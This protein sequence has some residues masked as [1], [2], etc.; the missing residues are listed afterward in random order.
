MSSYSRRRIP[1]ATYFFTVNLASRGGSD[2]TDRID[3]LRSAYRKTV[4]EHPVFC[5]AMVIL[6][7]HL[8]AVWTLPAQ[9][10]GFPERWRKIKAR[11]SHAIGEE[12]RRSSSKLAK[13]E[14]GVWQRRYW[15]HLIRDDADYRAH[16]AYCWGNPVKHGYVARAVDWPFS[17]IHRDIRA[18]RVEAEWS[19]SMPEGD[20]GEWG[21]WFARRW[22]A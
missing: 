1:G 15:E 6:P 19:G 2:L 5:D 8:H 21:G 9:D 18:G 16:V 12:R 3:L 22:V 4:V 11:F 14:L 20:F 17:S 7:D 10:A 13:R